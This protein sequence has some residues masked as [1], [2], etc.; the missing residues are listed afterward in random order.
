[1]PFKANK[2]QKRKAYYKKNVDIEKAL[3]KD[4]YNVNR[5][6][7]VNRVLERSQALESVNPKAG[8]RYRVA[9]HRLENPNVAKSRNREHVSTYRQNDP[10]KALARNRQSVL[11]YRHSIPDKARAQSR[12]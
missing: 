8:G 6:T 2:R 11:K 1:M 10:D 9:K 7:I 12:Q 5:E 4:Y 3:A